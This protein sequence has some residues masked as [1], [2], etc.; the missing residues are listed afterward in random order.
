MI[1]KGWFRQNVLTT[2]SIV[3]PR[4][5]GVRAFCRDQNKRGRD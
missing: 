2:E 3:N 4:V 5:E 1:A